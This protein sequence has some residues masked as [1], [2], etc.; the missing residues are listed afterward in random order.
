MR[1]R[2]QLPAYAGPLDL[3]LYLVRRN[4]LDVLDIPIAV[5]A[6]Q[7]LEIL[8]VIEQIDVDAVGDFLEM[9]TR[10]MEIKSRMMLPRQDEPVEEDAIDDPRTG[11]VERLLEYRRFKDAAEA[12]DEQSRQWSQR[13]ARRVNDLDANPQSPAEQPI[14]E[15]EL[16]DLVS[17]FARVIRDNAPARTTQIRYDDTPI[18]THMDRI[19]ER[20]QHVPRLAFEDLF[21]AGMNRA[22]MV[23]IFLAILELVRRRGVRVEQDGLFGEIWVLAPSRLAAAA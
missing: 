11:L 10:L 14:A 19:F 6:D 9:A 7:Y 1:F 20:L 16:W 18:E 13:F 22:Q 17:A 3:L 8:G 23:G 4:E 15:V 5:V 21:T 2:V 12:L